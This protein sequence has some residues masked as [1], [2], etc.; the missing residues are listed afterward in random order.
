MNIDAIIRE[1]Y[2]EYYELERNNYI[3]FPD[4]KKW[5]KSKISL[6]KMN[7]P[8]LLGYIYDEEKD[9]WIKNP[10]ECKCGD[11]KFGNYYRMPNNKKNAK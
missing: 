11:H 5:L 4:K 7:N 9:D 8:E 1:I 2:S 3:D 10:E 6:F